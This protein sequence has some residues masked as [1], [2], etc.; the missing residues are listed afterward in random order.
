[1]K[2]R[3]RREVIEDIQYAAFWLANEVHSLPPG[4]AFLALLGEISDEAIDL[5]VQQQAGKSRRF[6]PMPWPP[7]FTVTRV[8]SIALNGLKRIALIPHF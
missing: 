7:N 4:R 5:A 3:S 1:M 2:S 8:V 6:S